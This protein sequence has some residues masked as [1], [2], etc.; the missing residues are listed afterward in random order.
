[1]GELPI[2]VPGK[3]LHELQSLLIPDAEA[4]DRLELIV[5]TDC[6]DLA[7]RDMAAYLQLIDHV[8]GR[9]QPAG[10]RSYAMRPAQYLRVERVRS[11]SVELVIPEILKGVPLIAIVWLCLKYLPP[12]VESLA[13]A[14]DSVQ[15]GLLA[16]ESRKQI[17]R[18]VEQDER[19]AALPEERR[20]DLVALVDAI[21]QKD[22]SLVSKAA[23]FSEEH[24]VDVELR[25]EKVDEA[26]EQAHRAGASGS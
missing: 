16:R 12:A 15:Q 10:F 20:D 24:V 2:R 3:A 21:L 7:L 22:Q 23:R 19:L 5:R 13:K 25:F 9:L 17:G 8:Y 14:Y 11:G 4:G 26:S 18:R 6:R 1:M